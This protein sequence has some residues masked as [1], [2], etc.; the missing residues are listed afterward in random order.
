MRKVIVMFKKISLLFI[1]VLLIIIIVCGCA[2]SSESSLQVQRNDNGDLVTT[3]N[4][5]NTVMASS[6]PAPI[7][8]NDS[9]FSFASVEAYEVC[10]DYEYYLYLVAELDL[11][12][13]TDSEKHWLQEDLSKRAYISSEANSLDFDPA[14]VL[15]TLFDGD[16]AYVVFTSSFSKSYRHSFSNS[17]ALVI[18]VAEQEATHDYTDAEGKT[19]KLH[20]REEVDYKLTIP[21]SLPSA[22]SIPEPLYSY[23]VKWLGE[24]TNSLS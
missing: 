21:S 14:T 18:I 12:D 9:S 4:S 2:E 22:E 8:Y 6:L 23:I 19:Y 15:G 10:S 11:S 1:N 7:L 3:S 17:V 16:K 13:L 5:G 20:N 24:K